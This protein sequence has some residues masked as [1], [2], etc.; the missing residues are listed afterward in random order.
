MFFCIAEISL[1][2]KVLEWG[3]VRQW[4]AEYRDKKLV[5][6]DEVLHIVVAL[7]LVS[8]V[9]EAALV[10]KIGELRENVS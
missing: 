5:P 1:V 10:Q 7:M 3:F 2:E 9:V 4:D 6:A 8:K